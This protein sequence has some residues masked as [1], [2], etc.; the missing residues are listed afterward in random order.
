MVTVTMF[1]VKNFA[2]NVMPVMTYHHLT[3]MNKDQHRVAR[4]LIICG[5]LLV[6]L[7]LAA[8]LGIG[9]GGVRGRKV[10]LSTPSGE[11]A[12]YLCEPDHP[13][14]IVLALHSNAQ[15]LSVV[16]PLAREFARRGFI[17][18]SPYVQARPFATRL[19]LDQ[20]QQGVVVA[21]QSFRHRTPPFPGSLYLVGHSLGANQAV[22]LANRVGAAG[23]VAIGYDVDPPKDRAWPMLLMSGL[24]D[25]LH[26]AGQMR[27]V[28]LRAS[29]N[30]LSNTG[31]CL[32]ALADHV[33][34]VMDPRLLHFAGTWLG[35]RTGHPGGISLEPFRA[36]AFA[37][38]AL[39]LLLLCSGAGLAL[40][41]AFLGSSRP[42]VRLPG[43]VLVGLAWGIWW[44]MG[45]YDNSGVGD[46]GADLLVAL[47]LALVIARAQCSRPIWGQGWKLSARLLTCL[48]LVW[49]ATTVINAI[50]GLVSQP[51]AVLSLPL[52]A[53]WKLLLD[54]CQFRAWSHLLLMPWLVL[55][56]LAL[57][58][59]RPGLLGQ[60]LAAW[61]VGFIRSIQQL[62]FRPNFSTSA[63]GWVILLIAVA[64]AI[65]GWTRIIHEGYD[66]NP[67]ELFRLLKLLARLALLPILLLLLILRK[68]GTVT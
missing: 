55:P 29:A 51:S 23:V 6:A 32:S 61:V 15:T 34:E 66:L 25:Q 14:G 63:A 65:F 53:A 31:F 36:V 50:P 60:R 1:Y 45:G 3:F 58:L 62:R 22:L 43:P 12:G 9:D 24:Y 10:V 67:G 68:I 64:G 18:F 30:G 20:Y 41:A 27:E 49:L 40:H 21:A 54:L 47:L 2:I 7:G 13:Q 37:L 16:E 57:E 59:W 17:T 4:C 33:G 35:S 42:G 39:G 28:V 44:I 56:I 52:F 19:T 38:V 11:V 26:P 48:W 8:V 46:W 5:F